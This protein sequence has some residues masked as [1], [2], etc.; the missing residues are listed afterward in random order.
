[1]EILFRKISSNEI[2]FDTKFE[3]IRFLGIVKRESKD[4]VLCKGDLKGN[5][6]HTCDRCGDDFELVIDEKIELFASDGSYEK[7]NSLDIIE[8]YDGILDLNM[9]MHSE[10]EALKS[11]YNYCKKCNTK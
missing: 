7:E 1:M 5:V 10:L 4:L 6:S 2:H 8:F 11:D 3:E 9:I